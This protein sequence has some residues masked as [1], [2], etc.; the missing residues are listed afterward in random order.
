[1]E[2]LSTARGCILCST[3]EAHKGPLHQ[4]RGVRGTRERIC[5]WCGRQSLDLSHGSAG[6]T[7]CYATV[8][9]TSAEGRCD[10]RPV[11]PT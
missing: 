2:G 1:M 5:H 6:Q 4:L 10:T 11:D 7:G 9:Q 8:S 3:G